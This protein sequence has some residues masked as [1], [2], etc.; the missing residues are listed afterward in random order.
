MK[1]MD[2]LSTSHSNAQK[3]TKSR[4][5]VAPKA[6]LD[7]R[8]SLSSRFAAANDSQKSVESLTFSFLSRME[9]LYQRYPLLRKSCSSA[10]KRDIFL[11]AAFPTKSLVIVIPRVRFATEPHSTRSVGDK[12]QF[13]L[14]RE[15]VS[16]RQSGACVEGYGGSCLDD[17]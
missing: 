12:E 5:K 14:E 4:Y 2:V 16:A 3:S 6:A 7:C 8:V 11:R 9:S 1:Q 13:L 15:Y 10:L 17:P